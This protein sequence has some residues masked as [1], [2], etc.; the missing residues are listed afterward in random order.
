MNNKLKSIDMLKGIG[1]IMIIIV[2]NRHFILKNTEGYRALVNY[3]QMGCQIFFLV[4]GMALCYSWFHQLEKSPAKSFSGNYISFIIRR[5]MRLAPGFLIMLALNFILNVILIDI[6]HYSPGFI[7]TRTPLALLTNVFFIHGF[8]PDYINSVFPGGWYIG[9]S[10]ILYLLFPLLA[11]LCQKLRKISPFLI[12]AL[13]LIFLVI[14]VFTLR[15]IAMASGGKLYPSNNSFLYYFFTNQLPCFMLGIML[16]FQQQPDIHKGFAARCPLAVSVVLFA[17]T[18]F[19]SI[20]LYLLPE[21]MNYLYTIMPSLAGLAFYWLAVSMLH[22]ELKSSEKKNTKKAPDDKVL[23]LL[24]DFLAKCGRISY[25]MYLTHSLICW[26]GIKAI[27]SALNSNG[28]EYND[29]LFYML[30]LIPSIFIVYVLGLSME[31][32]LKKIKW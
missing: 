27:T 10:F 18:G 26:Y 5:Y 12:Y 8:F 7:M 23:S 4:S 17:L 11:A 32:L 15:H 24:A 30:T 21:K 1:I 20:K 19:I 31:L 28:Y 29:L 2:H 25:G 6:F 16:Y 13:P 9:T 22:V 14:N 3:G